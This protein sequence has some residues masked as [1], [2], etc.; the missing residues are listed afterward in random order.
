MSVI[1]VNY[2]QRTQYIKGYNMQIKGLILLGMIADFLMGCVT[3][4]AVYGTLLA[5]LTKLTSKKQ[6]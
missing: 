4:D 2:F 1:A 3:K 5:N 6:I